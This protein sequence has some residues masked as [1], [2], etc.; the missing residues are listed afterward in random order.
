MYDHVC[1]YYFPCLRNIS[2]SFSISFRIGYTNIDQT[3]VN[4]L[5]ELLNCELGELDCHVITT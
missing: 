5:H 4:S 2:V 3:L 1:R